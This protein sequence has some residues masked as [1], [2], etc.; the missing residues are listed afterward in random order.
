MPENC[1]I[2]WLKWFLRALILSIRDGS[3]RKLF[4]PRAN[5]VIDCRVGSSQVILRFE[6]RANRVKNRVKIEPDKQIIESISSQDKKIL[7][8]NFCLSHDIIRTKTKLNDH[9]I[10]TNIELL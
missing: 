7:S 4:E 10:C 1:V 9:S 8:P 6:L 5:R 2:P 3:S